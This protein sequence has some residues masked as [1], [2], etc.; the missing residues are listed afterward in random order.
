MQTFLQF[1]V[2]DEGYLM[3]CFAVT[4]IICIMLMRMIV[5][6]LTNDDQDKRS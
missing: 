4:S 5:S 2:S 3:L 6:A 1:V